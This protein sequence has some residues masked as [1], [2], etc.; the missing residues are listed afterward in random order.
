M[1]ARPLCTSAMPYI[2]VRVRLQLAKVYAAHADQATARH[3]M[4]EIDDILLHRP[5]T[6]RIRRRGSGV[7]RD[8][9]SNTQTRRRA[10]AHP[11][12]APPAA[13]LADASH[14]PRIGERLF[15]SRN[16]VSSQ[17]GS[18]YRKLGVSSRSDAVQQAMT[19][20]LLGG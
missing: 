20:G 8:L 18:V 14:V 11:R 17:V 19:V 2:A 6:R 7:P 10:P 9:A 5:R 4:R 13:V 15:V 1:R 16:T 12:R 3:L